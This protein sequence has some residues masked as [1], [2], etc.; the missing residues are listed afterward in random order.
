MGAAGEA[1]G[2]R[3]YGSGWEEGEA[4]QGLSKA[5]LKRSTLFKNSSGMSGR[6]GSLQSR[7]SLEL[8]KVTL[9]L[10]KGLG[11]GAVGSHGRI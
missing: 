9:H 2:R 8:R 6:Q 10:L 11:L 1:P 5:W 4:C 3:W 7:L